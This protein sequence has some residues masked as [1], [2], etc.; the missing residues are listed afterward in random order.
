MAESGSTLLSPENAVDVLAAQIGMQST[1]KPIVQMAA[2]VGSSYILDKLVELATGLSSISSLNLKGFQLQQMQRDIKTI[3]KNVK[4]LNSGPSKASLDFFVRE[5]YENAYRSA[6]EGFRDAADIET[7]VVATW[8]KILTEMMMKCKKNCDKLGTILKTSLDELLDDDMV[9]ECWDSARKQNRYPDIVAKRLESRQ[10]LNQIDKLLSGTYPML[11][12]H[13]GWT[14]PNQDLCNGV[15]DCVID[16]KYIPEGEEDKVSFPIGQ[17]KGEA[18]T[19]DIYK[20]VG[21]ILK[22]TVFPNADTTPESSLPT[23]SHIIK[24]RPSKS[25]KLKIVTTSKK[26]KKMIVFD[27]EAF[28]EDQNVTKKNNDVLLEA[29]EKEETDNNEVTKY[30]TENNKL[31]KELEAARAEIKAEADKSAAM[32]SEAE[33][34]TAEKVGAEELGR[35]NDKLKK[36]LQLLREQQEQMRG[37]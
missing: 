2:Y 31:K 21:N 9:S 14:S 24:S 25:Q 7:K 5:D 8:I 17:L 18:V 30:E 29:T 10:N 6:I 33:R 12:T 23:I 13:Q 15:S 4:I 37:T 27:L 3:D 1:S 36:E 11:S 22:C 26:N 34:L 16:T 28:Q 32:K 19:V 20:T 35:E